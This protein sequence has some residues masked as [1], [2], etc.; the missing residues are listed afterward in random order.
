ML[1]MWRRLKILNVNRKKFDKKRT[2]LLNP[3][4]H[5]PGGHHHYQYSHTDCW[6]L[7]LINLTKAFEAVIR[8]D[9]WLV[10]KLYAFLVHIVD[11]NIHVRTKKWHNSVFLMIWINGQQIVWINLNGFFF[12]WLGV[13]WSSDASLIL[14]SFGHFRVEIIEKSLLTPSVHITFWICP[15]NK[16]WIK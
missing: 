15:F 3:L 4:K 13:I 10:I 14:S 8:K 5:L 6:L 12:N 7:Q 2:T 1:C 9:L 11:I 16:Y